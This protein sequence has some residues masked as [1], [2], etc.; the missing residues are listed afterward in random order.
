MKLAFPD[1]EVP[2]VQ[3]SLRSSLDPKEH[4]AAGRALEPLRNQ[5]VLIVGSGMSFHNMERLRR[6]GS[7]A[8]PDS[9]K[10]DGWL[11]ETVDLRRDRREGRL[12][13][14]ENAPGGRASHPAE[15]HLIP[16]HVVAGAA[17]D[18]PGRKVF[19]DTVIGSMQSAFMFG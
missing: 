19:S 3:L 12:L 8:D 14:W 6:G 5:G 4:L 10:F 15:E 2:V 18:D 17:G 13:D 9:Q 16:L 7:A 1:A 11:E